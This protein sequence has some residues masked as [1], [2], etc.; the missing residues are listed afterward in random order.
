MGQEILHTLK[1]NCAKFLNRLL[2]VIG[3]KIYFLFSLTHKTSDI[4]RFVNF[5][6]ISRT[7][8]FLAKKIVDFAGISVLINKI[9]AYIF[10]WTTERTIFWNQRQGFLQNFVNRLKILNRLINQ[11]IVSHYV[12]LVLQ[13]DYLTAT[14]RFA[15]EIII[16]IP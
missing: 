5:I 12:R 10:F 4:L 7:Y 14:K 6:S 15:T 11:T 16:V 1:Y 9:T 13:K 8:C 3:C 2:C